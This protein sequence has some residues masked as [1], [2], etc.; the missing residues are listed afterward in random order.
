M[1]GLLYSGACITVRLLAGCD[2]VQKEWARDVESSK[3]IAAFAAADAELTGPT[4]RIARNR[5]EKVATIAGGSLW[6]IK[7]PPRG[8]IINRALVYVPNGWD[9][10]LAFAA[11]KKQ[12]E[13][14]RA[15]VDT[16]A[17]RVRAARRRGDVR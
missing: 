5:A 17:D 15:W 11:K 3:L 14:P 16:A 8:K 1:E 13:L 6:E 10:H 7:G 4:K 9:M 12:Q 2:A